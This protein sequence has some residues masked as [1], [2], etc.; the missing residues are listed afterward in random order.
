MKDILASHERL[1]SIEYPAKQ[2]V[3]EDEMEDALT[4]SS[5]LQWESTSNDGILIEERPMAGLIRLF[6][7]ELLQNF[8]LENPKMLKEFTMLFTDSN[9]NATNKGQLLNLQQQRDR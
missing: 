3:V 8:T 4:Q 1:K 7:F 2:V 5:L 6:T 9:L